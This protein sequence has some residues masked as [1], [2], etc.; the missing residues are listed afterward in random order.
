ME[1]GKLFADYDISGE[2]ISVVSQSSIPLS[3]QNENNWHHIA[4]VFDNDQK[5]MSYVINGE[6]KN[7][8]DLKEFLMDYDW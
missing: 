5:Q 3:S 4:F 1:N 8:N 7:S 2:T 6:L